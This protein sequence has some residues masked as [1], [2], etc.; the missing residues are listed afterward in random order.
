[1]EELSAP[2]DHILR[3]RNSLTMAKT[4]PFNTG[5]RNSVHS[6]PMH[7]LHCMSRGE[8]HRHDK[9]LVHRKT[10]DDD[11]LVIKNKH[12]NY[13]ASR[14]TDC[15]VFAQENVRR[16]GRSPAKKHRKSFTSVLTG[17]VNNAC[18]FSPAG[19]IMLVR[20]RKCD[21]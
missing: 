15:V 18:C 13:W 19:I 2:S 4:A 5:H 10:L 16:R 3:H 8:A 6:F 21:T 9:S 17:E 20:W 7:S 11:V 12:R 14:S 1:M